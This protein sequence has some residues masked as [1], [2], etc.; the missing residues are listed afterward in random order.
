MQNSSRDALLR[1]QAPH[2]GKTVEDVG[3]LVHI[4]L[5]PTAERAVQPGPQDAAISHIVDGRLNC[6]S[7]S[8]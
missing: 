8:T 5:Q 4:L 1:L 7:N 2:L 3:G 6:L